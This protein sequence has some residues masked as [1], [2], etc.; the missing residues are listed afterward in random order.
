MG[1]TL[2]LIYINDLDCDLV[3]KISKFADDTKV[4]GKAYT[5]E[6]CETIQ[7]DLNKLS[8]WSDKWL[9]K[10]NH[11]KCK[12]MHIGNDNLRYNYQMQSTPL[13]KTKREQDLGVIISSDL[14]SSAHCAAACKKAN[15]M[16]GFISR[17]FKY[18]TPKVMT[19]LYTSLVR[20]HLEYGVQFWSPCYVKDQLKLESVQRRATK[21]IPSL[22]NLPYEARLK[23]LNMFSLK[24]R[25]IRGDLI[26]TFKILKG[27][28]NIN[29]E[30]LFER[31]P[32][33][34]TRN[35]GFK[36]ITQ[37]FRTDLHKNYFNLRVVNRWN[38]LPANV[39]EANT[40]NTFKSRLDAYFQ[41]NGF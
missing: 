40:I 21:L 9:L 7:R 37:R 3:S 6:D 31:A 8:D 30:D 32:Q 33:A 39:V 36:L 24:E 26:E 28:D 14:K 29:C 22:R 16:L 20:P 5:R 10:F 11:D 1:P 27:F 2:F 4:G 35:N 25:R 38:N 15:R 41:V 34:S 12:V 23:K 18:K 13:T 19:H 17:S